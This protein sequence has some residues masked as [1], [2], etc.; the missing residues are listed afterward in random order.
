MD[1]RRE[2]AARGGTRVELG[3]A[4]ELGAAVSR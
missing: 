4:D 3:D 1:G 2:R